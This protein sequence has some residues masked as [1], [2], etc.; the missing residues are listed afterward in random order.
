MKIETACRTV[1]DGGPGA[2][3][4]TFNNGR[5]ERRRLFCNPGTLLLCEMLP[6]KRRKGTI[7]SLAEISGMEKIEKMPDVKTKTTSFDIFRHNF[8]KIYRYTL[9][10]GLSPNKNKGA[11]ALLDAPEKDLRELYD[12][13]DNHWDKIGKGKPFAEFGDWYNA[14]I[15]KAS[16]LGGGCFSV[17]ELENL[18]NAR[19]IKSIPYPCRERESEFIRIAIESVVKNH[20]PHSGMPI[21]ESYAG[22]EWRG[23]YDYSIHIRWENGSD[24][25][26]G[27]YAEEYHGCGNGYYWLLL[28]HNHVMFVEKD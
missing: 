1:Q 21:G 14:V 6:R 7:I 25:A 16:E 27:H 10:S 13:L 18:R 5:A 17:D 15:R 22:M 12:M 4:I 11:K 9:S 20:S 2:Y 24:Q 3:R 19:S 8:E 28:D 26:C 23:K